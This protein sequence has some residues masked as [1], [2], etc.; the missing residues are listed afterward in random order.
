MPR[1]EMDQHGANREQPAQEFPYDGPYP[2]FGTALNLVRG[3]E[4]AWQNRK[5]SSFI[6]TPLFCGYDYYLDPDQPVKRNYVR[7]AYR[8]TEDYA[9]KGGPRLGTAVAISGAAASPNMGFHTNAALAFLMTVFNVRLGAWF[10]NP[11]HRTLWWRRSSPALGLLYL[12]RELFPRTSDD[13]HY[14]Y[15]SDGGHFENL[16]LY[17]LIRRQCRFIVVGDGSCDEKMTFQDLGMAIEKCRRDFGVEIGIKLEKLVLNDKL[18]ASAHFAIGT[19]D[20]GDPKSPGYLLYIKPSLVGDETADVI[21]YCNQHAHFPHDTTANQ[22]FTESQ[23]ESYRALGQH[24]L[25]IIVALTSTTPSAG[26]NPDAPA[27]LKEMLQKLPAV[28]QTPASPWKEVVQPLD[29]H[30]RISYR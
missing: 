1:E 28:L 25:G 29:Q 12:L 5:A 19:I 26:G 11:R 16:G 22:F 8:P 20:Y 9:R 2:I 10:A 23:F 30:L 24:I 27:S 18:R 14:V 17:E 6:F 7:S 3:K 13:M 21:A 15:L 4:L